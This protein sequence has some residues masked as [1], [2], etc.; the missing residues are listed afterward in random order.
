MAIEPEEDRIMPG[1]LIT[2]TIVCR[3]YG[4][5]DGMPL[6]SLRSAI[7]AGR[8]RSYK[9]LRRVLVS[10]RDVEQWIRASLRV[11]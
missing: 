9:P 11:V 1:D 7:K 8:L 4:G 10:R 6:S 3:D 2:L 5:R